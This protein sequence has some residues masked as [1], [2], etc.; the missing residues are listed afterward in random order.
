[1]ARSV[2]ELFLALV[3]QADLE[4]VSTVAAQADE[5]AVGGDYRFAVP[6]FFAA[7]REVDAQ[8]IVLRRPA[9]FHDIGTEFRND[10]HRAVRRQVDDVRDTSRRDDFDRP[11]REL[12]R[13]A[14][15]VLV[16]RYRGFRHGGARF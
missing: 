10:G 16:S 7:W 11:A 4:F 9:S 6:A 15:R 2:D 12:G 5:F 3:E 8:G 1:S 13:P 14:V